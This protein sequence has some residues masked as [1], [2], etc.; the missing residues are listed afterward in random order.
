MA[1][2]KFISGG[3]DGQIVVWQL[4][5]TTTTTPLDTNDNAV[6]SDGGA[7]GSKKGKRQKSGKNKT[8]A[9]KSQPPPAKVTLQTVIQPIQQIH[10]DLPINWLSVVAVQE[11]TS[12][13]A[14]SGEAVVGASAPTEAVGGETNNGCDTG[15]TLDKPASDS[16]K[17]STETTESQPEKKT[18]VVAVADSSS[19]I[20]LYAL[21]VW[22]VV[23]L[24][25]VYVVF[26]FHFAPFPLSAFISEVIQASNDREEWY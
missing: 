14:T 16:D 13:D 12:T 5:Q 10:H 17:E 3:N 20:V 25:V 24:L 18:I 21:R 22:A 4:F 1:E 26:F 9:A 23:I 7:S 11:E 2:D 6:S 15:K 19:D 8:T